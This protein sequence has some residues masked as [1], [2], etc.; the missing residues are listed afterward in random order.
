MKTSLTETKQ[1]DDHLNGRLVDG[2]RLLFDARLLVDPVLRLNVNIQN[3]L[4]ALVKFYGRRKIKQEAIAIQDKMFNDDSF[5][6][7]ILNIFSKP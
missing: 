7:N 3:K 2:E 5:R 1:I 4:Y 6:K